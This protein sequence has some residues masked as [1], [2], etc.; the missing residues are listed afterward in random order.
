MSVDEK[1]VREFAY[2]IWE[3]EGR[4]EGQEARHWEMAL[5]LAEAE[6]GTSSE[7]MPE[8]PKRARRTPAA[9]TEAPGA[10]ADEAEQP[11]K[12]S[13]SVKPKAEPETTAKASKNPK[14]AKKPKA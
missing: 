4:P 1:R 10:P 14:A 12:K 13:R 5:R 7:E 11:V 3:S 9:R 6:A 8:K 2:Q